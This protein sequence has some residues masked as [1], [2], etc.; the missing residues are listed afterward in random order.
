MQRK[1]TCLTIMKFYGQLK[2]KEGRFGTW[3]TGLRKPLKTLDINPQHGPP[4]VQQ[5]PLNVM[6]IVKFL[7]NLTQK[8]QLSVQTETLKH[9]I[10]RENSKI[11]L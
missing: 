7:E 6:V 1:A 3:R 11:V 4:H 5:K 10:K 2:W 9:E 8:T